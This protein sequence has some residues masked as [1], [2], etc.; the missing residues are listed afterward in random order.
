MTWALKNQKLRWHEPLA[1]TG[2]GDFQAGR[3]GLAANL[4]RIRSRVDGGHEAHPFVSVGVPGGTNTGAPLKWSG[5][6]DQVRTGNPLVN[7]KALCHLSYGG[8][9][10][11]QRGLCYQRGPRCRLLI[12]LLVFSVSRRRLVTNL[13]R[14]VNEG[15]E[16]AQPSF[17]AGLCP[18]A[19]LW[20]RVH[21]VT[22][23]RIH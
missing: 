12:A 21:H 16:A 14:P 23:R 7:S 3:Y 13:D 11:W 17:A 5:P 8:S 19:T 1:L 22:R 10:V 9:D 6:A 20:E 15:F 2:A 4:T 18:P